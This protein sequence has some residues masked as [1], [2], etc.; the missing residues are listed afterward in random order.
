[1][2]DLNISES[3]SPT[4]AE[5]RQL[6]EGMGWSLRTGALRVWLTPF[7]LSVLAIAVITWLAFRLDL[8]VVTGGFLFLIVVVLS[9]ASGGFWSGTLTS[10]V[11]AAFM[12]YFFFPPLFHWN[13]DDPMNWVALG[14]FEFTALVVTLL[15]HRVQ[16]KAA[17][18]AAA[19]QGSERLYNAARGIL[20]LD[21]TGELGNRITALIREEFDL[22]GVVLFDEP[23]ACTFLAGNCPPQTEQRVRDAYF[24]NLDAYDPDTQT[25]FCVL[26]AG[27]RPVG[28]L[29]LCG[30]SMPGV[31]AQAI[32]SLCAI[33]LERARS[34]AKETRAEAGRQAEQLRSAVV[35]ALA[36]QIKT[37]LC[38]IQVACSTLP[39]LGE[40]SGAQ[41]EL[42]AAIDQQSTK[43]NDL[44][45]RLLGAGDLT[46]AK[47]EPQLAPVRLSEL[48][49]AAIGGVEDQVQRARFQVSVEGEEAPAL[50]DGKLMVIALTQIVDNAV[51]YSVPRSPITVRITMDPGEI[52]VRVQNQ[53]GVIAPADR[54]RIFER[55]YRTPEARQGPVGTGLGLSIA[56]RIVDAHHGRIGVES[57]PVEGTTFSIALP[58]APENGP[59]I[60]PADQPPGGAPL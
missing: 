48:A 43:L 10:I 42:V 8:N 4:K 7:L 1:M 18:A 24:Q 36:H 30:A 11:A 15:Q 40:L 56:K 49:K 32:A 31:V 5:K 46:S 29:A 50:A 21:K 20:F 25:R 6:G 37:P 51:K 52:S 58:G 22:R 47:I 39:A 28:G 59:G 53:G 3:P 12:D 16:L 60:P 38:V 26:R 23:A 41:A 9:A 54:E 55:F 27:S 45:T 57:G 19:Q 2:F 35:E 33:S 13:I 44:V 14:T 17:E 34:F